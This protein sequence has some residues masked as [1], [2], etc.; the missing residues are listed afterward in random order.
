MILAAGLTP[1]WQQV[2]IFDAFTPGEV[3]RARQVWWCASGKVLNVARALHHLGGPARALT[4]VGGTPGAEIRRDFEQLGIAARWIEASAPTR[5]CTTILDTARHLATELVPEAGPLT[6]GERAAFLA[7]YGEEAGDAAVVVLIGSLPPGTPAGCYRELV[8]QSQG[9]VI[10]DA[11]G[12]ELLDALP[13]KPFLVK[14][15]RE[16]LGR[17]LARDLHNDQGLFEAMAELNQRGAAWVVITAGKN[18]LYAS[19]RDRFYRIESLAMEAINPIGCGDCMA[20]GIAWALFQGREPLDAIRYGVAAAADKVG[21]L[22]PGVVD[23]TRVEALAASI[24]V[25]RL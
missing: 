11:R 18:P 23:R 1:A 5:T 20:A 10:L 24:E 22:L 4:P 3:N 21:R 14:P 19:N 13:A 12:T 17:T 15:N 9:R 16:E 2:L 6:A 25:A 7:A 8:E